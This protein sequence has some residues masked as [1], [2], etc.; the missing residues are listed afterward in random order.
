VNK[1]L[2]VDSGQASRANRNSRDG[3]PLPLVTESI[4]T[5]AQLIPNAL[6]LQSESQVLTYCDLEAQANRLAH[7]LQSI[8]VGP[9]VLVGVCLDRGPDMVVAALA[10]LKA[11]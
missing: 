11:G 8:G 4:A 3:E 1:H 2:P 6:A 7:H 10:V 5:Q 9:E